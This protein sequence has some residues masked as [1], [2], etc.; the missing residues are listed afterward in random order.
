MAI[1]AYT[2]YT[3][4]EERE[5][6]E[7]RNS[8]FFYAGSL[9]SN[10]LYRR[11]IHTKTWEATPTDAIAGAAAQYNH[12]QGYPGAQNP[13]GL[14]I[15]DGWRLQAVEYTRSLSTP[16][17]KNV[18]ETWIKTGDWEDLGDITPPAPQS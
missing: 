11:S 7:Y 6:Y 12:D 3:L 17:S 5:E 8:Y 1:Y 13:G 16:M 2:N 10:H 15:N 14:S 9:V 18:R 4:V